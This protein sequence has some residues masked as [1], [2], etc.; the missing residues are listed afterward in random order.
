MTVKTRIL[1]TLVGFVVIFLLGW[2][3]YGFL[4]MDFY[5]AN[6]GSATGVPRDEADMVWWALI[7]GNLLQAYF[8][9]Y[10]FGKMGHVN[11]FMS[12]LS[13]GAI[14]GL[15]LGLAMN[16]TMFGTT[17]MMNL[18]ATMV[19]PFASMIMMGL[20]GGVIGMMLGRD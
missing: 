15:I 1:A 17:N 12:G 6:S 14:I 20:T 3:L 18:T 2:L 9:V 5:G 7:V 4:L 19:D 16:L 10:I 11:S 13:T 8:L